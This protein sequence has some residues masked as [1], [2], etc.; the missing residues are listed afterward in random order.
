MDNASLTLGKTAVETARA[1]GKTIAT[2]ES[3]TG[4]LISATL[5]SVPGSSAV[6]THGF[7]TYANQAKTDVLGVDEHLIRDFGAVSREVAEAM[8]AGARSLSGADIAV[9]VTGIAGPGG[10]SAEKTVGLV[11]FG[12]SSSFGTQTDRKVFT[13]TSRE[14]VRARATQHALRLVIA[15]LTNSG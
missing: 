6:F 15:R 3:C 2:A 8:A 5:T 14:L 4:G 10:G 1:A 9:S 11:W 12:V 13:P 7:V